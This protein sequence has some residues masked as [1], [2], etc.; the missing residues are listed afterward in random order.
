MADTLFE[1]QILPAGGTRA[2]A[3]ATP[4]MVG[5]E[6]FLTKIQNAIRDLNSSTI[7]Y[8]TGQGGIGK[9]R[10]VTHF[11]I[12]HPADLPKPVLSGMVDMYDIVTNTIE[13]FLRRTQEVLTSGAEEAAEVAFQVY[14]A[15][16]Q[17][18]DK[19]RI[20]GKSGKE[21]QAQRDKMIE[22]F[23]A[24]LQTLSQSHR[25]VL[26]LDTAEKL[27]HRENPVLER[28]GLAEERPEILTWFLHAFLPRLN[29]IKM[30]VLVAGR[31]SPSTRKQSLQK[32]LQET[33][34]RLAGIKYDYIWLN[35]L[36]EQET[37]DYFDAVI[38]S[39]K[40]TGDPEDANVAEF[41]G[42][43]SEIDRRVT[44]YC[45]C[46]EGTSPH[47]R[48]I[49]LALAIDHLVTNGRPL[50][51][52]RLTLEQAQQL[53]QAERER[54]K[55]ELGRAL[56]KSLRDSAQPADRVLITLSVL[57]LG[58]DASILSRV[59]VDTGEEE[60]T[61]V[62][63][64]AI[65]QVRRLSF[66]KTRS[67]Q[68]IILHDEM[69]GLLQP[70]EDRYLPGRDRILSTMESLSKEKIERIREEICDLTRPLVEGTDEE[71]DQATLDYIADA[72]RRLQT[73]ILE[74]L[75]YR[76]RRD[77]RRGFQAFYRFSE[78]A[79][80]AGD[81]ILGSQLQAELLQFL[82]EYDPT[83]REPEVEGLRRA[84]VMAD[85]AVRQVQWLWRA[86]RFYDALALI[87]KL[88]NEAQDL[89][90]P[91]DRLTGAK[92]NSWHGFM[93]GLIGNYSRAKTLLKEAIDV[94]ES[95]S[96]HTV[97]SAGI[98]ARAYNNLGYVYRLEGF[99]HDAIRAYRQ[100]VSYWRVADFR[101]SQAQ[102]LNNLA[103]TCGLIG[104]FEAADNYA[105]DALNLRLELGPSMPTGL[106]LTTLARIEIQRYNLDRGLR[107]SQRA[108]ELYY[109]LN[110][111]RG[112]GLALYVLAEAKRRIS[113]TLTYRQR[114]QSAQMLAEACQH[115]GEAARIFTEQIPE[116]DW[117]ARAFIELGC[118]YRDWALLRQADPAMLAPKETAEQNLSVE[119]L[120]SRSEQAF[121][122][123]LASVADIPDLRVD[124]LLNLAQLQYLK[125][126]ELGLVSPDQALAR[127]DT[128]LF[129]E[130]ERVILDHYREREPL[131]ALTELFQHGERDLHAVF[132]GRLE[133]L[134]GQIAFRFFEESHD[135]E[136]L[137]EAAL[138]FTLSLEY[139][140]LFSEKSF[141][142]MRAAR[143]RLYEN[144]KGLN[145]E[146][147]NILVENAAAIE[148]LYG[149]NGSQM[150]R[151]LESNFGL[152]DKIV[153]I[154]G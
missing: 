7:L 154:D 43:L 19:F 9:T 15:E 106:S 134:R 142:E 87:E 114:R 3:L 112:T 67:D 57:R 17:T 35:G 85:L 151:F 76:L 39:T 61:R 47:I 116:P 41:V 66:V 45:L 133:L 131:G 62:I 152:R 14:L 103:F 86:N 102:T 113:Q 31:P 6:D 80:E 138:H 16:R 48:P 27:F 51:D 28:L 4:D 74:D 115:S 123:G 104:D 143:H 23:F 101:F 78:E 46:D 92:L 33:S 38:R 53:P 124:I 21:L 132:L 71:L 107:W 72:R 18:L 82:T 60:E 90:A 55:K 50:E 11:L 44:F 26:V 2:G 126:F 135:R 136:H 146:E 148:K 49:L 12:Y 70:A 149:L 13:G 93:E 89:I 141:R 24:G 144:L 77:A 98:L 91:K 22:A 110:N 147:I 75:H 36:T 119:T 37:L 97:R 30:V 63:N 96:E 10:L 81:E 153:L 40:K 139:L 111:T 130:I 20:I 5:R 129:P 79:V 88:K 125:M 117:R 140:G 83:G 34:A 8:I 99:I 68:R 108:L 145:T 65:E 118:A 150:S 84:D 120:V 122:D 95:Y 64:Q 32:M 59:L 100:A 42:Q 54:I 127:L 69:Y 73:A 1:A 105:R 29:K 25:L 94:L 121:Q 137:Q 52:F 128:H 109:M 58:A 56:I